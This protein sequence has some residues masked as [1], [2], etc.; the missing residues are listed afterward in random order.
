MIFNRLEEAGRLRQ[1][2]PGFAKAFD[3][4]KRDDLEELPVGTYELDGRRV[5]AM[6]Q[7]GVGMG[8]DAARLETHR[9]YIDIQFTLSGDELIGCGAV[10]Q[11]DAK[12]WDVEKDLCFL[13]GAPTF[14]LPIPAGSFAV[15]YPEEDA[16]A[17][18][19]G[20]SEFR[21][22]VVKIEA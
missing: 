2:H 4:L 11:P 14:W 15:F 12:G 19:A 6:V 18:M 20:V 16:H 13:L 7:K 10:G 1:L 17:P 5:Y 3:F 9:K 22:V 21:K 8:I